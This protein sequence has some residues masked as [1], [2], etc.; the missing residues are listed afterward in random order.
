MKATSHALAASL[1]CAAGCE[2]P[3]LVELTPAQHEAIALQVDLLVTSESFHKGLVGIAAQDATFDE[4]GQMGPD[5]YRESFADAVDLARRLE[6][7]GRF[8][9]YHGDVQDDVTAHSSAFYGE[10]EDGPFITFNLDVESLDDLRSSDILHEALHAPF[11]GHSASIM[12][13]SHDA[14]TDFNN[15]EA[16]FVDVVLQEKDLPYLGSLYGDMIDSIHWHASFSPIAEQAALLESTGL[17]PE[18]IYE[19]LATSGLAQEKETWLNTTIDGIYAP[20]ME[21]L[22]VHKDELYAEILESHIFYESSHERYLSELQTYYEQ[23]VESRRE[24][25]REHRRSTR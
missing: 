18:E 25:R 14:S 11:A 10:N 12:D 7:T 24:A 3:P 5:A 20:Y 17:T 16:N 8:F 6:K 13:I 9:G 23:E 22:G 19:T 15:H 2:H 1:I 4:D 21:Q